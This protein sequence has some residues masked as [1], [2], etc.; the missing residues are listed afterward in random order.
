VQNSE[1]SKMATHM[2]ELT[3]WK[4]RDMELAKEALLGPL[5]SQPAS[6]IGKYFKHIYSV[7][8]KELDRFQK[9]V[10]L[11]PKNCQWEKFLL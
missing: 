4:T 5:A 8:L 9:L 1:V 10:Y 11:S 2:S 3:G 7:C 6:S